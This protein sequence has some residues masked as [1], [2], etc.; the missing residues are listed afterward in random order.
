[1]SH[2][3]EE[4]HGWYTGTVHPHNGYYAGDFRDRPHVSADLR[5]VNRIA[6]SSSR[7]STGRGAQGKGS[8]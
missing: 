7:G 1:M 3:I 4:E 5:Y 6:A 2:N 8:A